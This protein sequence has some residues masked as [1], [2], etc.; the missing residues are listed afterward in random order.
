MSLPENRAETRLFEDTLP[1]AADFENGIDQP[2][3][4]KGT[5]FVC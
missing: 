2:R 5:V 1:L 4:D 3:T